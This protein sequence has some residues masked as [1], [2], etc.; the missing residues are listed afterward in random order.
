LLIPLL[1]AQHPAASDS[2]W[3]SALSSPG[4]ALPWTRTTMAQL[5]SQ[6]LLS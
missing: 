1:L 2:P 6:R 5:E 4:M 3:N